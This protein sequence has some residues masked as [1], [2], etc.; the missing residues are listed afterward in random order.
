MRKQ[1]TK[2]N[3]FFR[4]ANKSF[5]VRNKKVRDERGDTRNDT[6]THH[7]VIMR[8]V[9]SPSDTQSQACTAIFQEFY[10]KHL[11]VVTADRPSDALSDRFDFLFILGCRGVI[12]TRNTINNSHRNVILTKGQCRALWLQVGGDVVIRIIKRTRW[13]GRRG[14][15]IK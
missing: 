13:R 3:V 2:V 14:I 9:H 7:D 12:L 15:I 6:D 10:G 1:R 5:Q 4:L 11:S 8:C